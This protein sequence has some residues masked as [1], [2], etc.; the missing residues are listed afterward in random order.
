MEAVLFRSFA[1]LGKC[2]SEK[3]PKLLPL[4]L[5]N[6]R[7]SFSR[8]GK[9]QGTYEGENVISQLFKF[10]KLHQKLFSSSLSS[11]F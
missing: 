3:A 6:K 8:K 10:S 7:G 2:I 9:K 4:L 5:E 1:A 11:F